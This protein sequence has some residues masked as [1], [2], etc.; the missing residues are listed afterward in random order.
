MTHV[1]WGAILLAATAASCTQSQP[2]SPKHKGAGPR[3]EITMVTTTAKRQWLE[4]AVQRF[5]QERPEV[6]VIIKFAASNEEIR[7]ILQGADKP[8]IFSPGEG[9]LLR[10]LNMQ[11][12]A[13]HGRDLVAA[14]GVEASHSLLGTPVV[15][16]G[17]EAVV[18]P[19]LAASTDGQLSW[20]AIQTE[21]A[22]RRTA[23]LAPLRLG[24]VALSKGSSGLNAV[25]LM[26]LEL[27]DGPVLTLEQ[28]QDE[29]L[30]RKVDDIEASVTLAAPTTSALAAR[31]A[32][33]GP[34]GLDLIF[35]YENTASELVRAAASRGVPP[36]HIYYPKYAVRSDQPAAVL[37]ADWV[38]PEQHAAALAWLE[39]LESR[40]MQQE[41]ARIGLRP[42][43]P[44]LLDMTDGPFA[45]L[46]PYG[47]RRM[48]PP[49]A[50][51]PS[52]E[53][54]RALVALVQRPHPA[55]QVAAH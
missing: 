18:R 20:A 2:E 33:G 17:D 48:L 31:F 23:K 12:R 46:K 5:R 34:D 9:A 3:T 22:R 24:H 13:L 44:S 54:T 37:Q 42:N 38:T 7:A 39:F 1:R 53:V 19:I 26:G 40:P 32:H 52:A 30:A 36:P 41:A 27:F 16:L 11:W 10:D 29:R 45:L 8:T 55:V 6:R 4:A 49:A 51:K 35:T 43:D 14:H 21:S 15:F 28:A 47:F 50:P 25:L